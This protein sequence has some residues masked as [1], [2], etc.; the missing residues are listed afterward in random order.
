MVTG[1]DV[2][3]TDTVLTVYP[4][5]DNDFDR[6]WGMEIIFQMADNTTDFR[7]Y[8]SQLTPKTIIDI[9]SPEIVSSVIDTG[10]IFPSID[11]INPRQYR[12]VTF[13]FTPASDDRGFYNFREFF[14]P[15]KG[16]PIAIGLYIEGKLVDSLRQSS[17]DFASINVEPDIMMVYPNP[18]VVNNM[19][20]ANLKIQ[21]QVPTDQLSNYLYT[22]LQLILNIYNLSGEHVAFIDTIVQVDP[23]NGYNSGDK[24]V[25]YEADWDMKNSSGI[26]VAS[27]VYLIS[28]ALYSEVG[29]ELLVEKITK[30]AIIR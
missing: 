2:Q 5:L 12:S 9:T 23:F 29:G 19:N 17:I 26:D 3:Y 24:V 14:I 20:N 11:F 10:A 28:A 6:P 22:D 15:K 25:L 7:V 30:A 16:T 27:G 4:G 21:Y 8:Q 18:A 1:F 13:V